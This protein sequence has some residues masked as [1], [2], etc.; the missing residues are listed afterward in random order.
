MFDFRK[1]YLFE[2]KIVLK[3]GLAIST[4]TESS[5]TFLDEF[6]ADRANELFKSILSWNRILCIKINGSQIWA[7]KSTFGILMTI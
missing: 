6:H 7:F 3:T 4:A 5:D 2:N 1:T